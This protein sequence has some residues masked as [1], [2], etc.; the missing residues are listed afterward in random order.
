MSAENLDKLMGMLKNKIS[1]YLK[2]ISNLWLA[3]KKLHPKNQLFSTSENYSSASK[4][5]ITK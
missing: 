1:I 4:E 2:K 3:S 5:K